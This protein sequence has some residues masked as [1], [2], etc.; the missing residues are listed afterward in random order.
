MSLF[1][2]FMVHTGAAFALLELLLMFITALVFYF[3]PELNGTG[4]AN[5]IIWGITFAIVAAPVPLIV[6]VIYGRFAAGL[7]SAEQRRTAPAATQWPQ[8]TVRSW[9]RAL[10]TSL[11]VVGSLVFA[12]MIFAIVEPRGPIFGVVIITA[13]IALFW[14]CAPFLA[15]RPRVGS[16][17]KEED[18]E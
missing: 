5:A 9:R 8:K 11:L 14:G 13:V 12:P 1:K 17:A 2:T 18:D 15:R 16:N 7:D 10:A 3:H 6:A 4:F